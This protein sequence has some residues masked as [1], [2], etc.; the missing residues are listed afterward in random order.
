[1]AD[2]QVPNWLD[3][4]QGVS[5]RS[6]TLFCLGAVIGLAVAGYALF[7]AKGTSTL[8][9]PPDAIALVNQQPISRSDFAAQLRTLYDT[10]PGQATAEQRRKV[11]NDLIREELFVQRAKELDVGAVDPEVRQAMV[12]AVEQQAAADAITSAPT[13]A[14]LQAFFEAHRGNYAA[15]GV[16]AVRDLVFPV[17]AAVQAG[18]TAQALRGGADVARFTARD[19]RKTEGEEF[20]FAAKIHLG[21]RLF[22]AARALPDHGVT[23]PLAEGGSLHVLYMAQNRRP[24]PLAYAEAKP[25][26]LADYRRQAIDR[27]QSGNEGFL[28]KR[29][30][31]LVAKD[32]R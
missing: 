26:V 32:L 22:E 6:L 4:T 16:M 21:P 1:M 12:G 5:V 25:Q 29:A 30:N 19:S 3:P 9:V 18:E 20:Y 17:A 11:L 31:V 15:E 24:M 7:T 23:G 10:A 14:K 13:E 27:L 28:R 8:Y 2:R